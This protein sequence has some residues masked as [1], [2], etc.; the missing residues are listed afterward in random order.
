MPLILVM[1]MSVLPVVAQQQEACPVIKLETERLPDLNIPRAGHALFYARLAEGRLQGKNGELTVAGGH[2][3]GFVPTPTAEYLK[4]GKWHTMP[5]TY[6]MTSVSP[7]CSSRVRSF[8]PED[9][10][11]PQASA[12]LT[13]PN[14]TIRRL[15]LSEALAI[16]TKSVSG[17]QPWNSTVDRWL[18]PATGI[19]RTV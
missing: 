12:R 7:W 1:M 3:N 18:S 13:L 8:L 14:F 19:K 17:P 9:V 15:T 11:S 6:T 2:T 16:C 10:S 4:D 5:M